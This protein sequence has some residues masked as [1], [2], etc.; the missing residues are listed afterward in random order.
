MKLIVV[1]FLVC[2]MINGSLYSNIYS[3]SNKS[4]GWFHGNC[5]AI[6]NQNIPKG[7]EINL[8][9][10]E[11]H[12][13]AI[14]AEISG[15]ITDDSQCSALFADRKHVNIDAGKVSFYQ[16]SADTILNVGIGILNDSKNKYE[17]LDINQDGVNDKFYSCTSSEGIHF[18][19]SDGTTN[20]IIWNGYYYLGYDIESNCP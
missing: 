8:I 18:K 9:T 1:T 3:P 6:Y 14:K 10:T 5:I 19:I 7:T 15:K 13:N 20:N 2:F 17:V 11:A 16:V 12:T 4:I